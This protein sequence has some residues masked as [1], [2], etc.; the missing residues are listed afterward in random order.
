ALLEHRPLEP[1]D[2]LD[3]NAGRGGDLFRGL[4]GT[5]ACLDLLGAQRALHFDLVLAE[6]GEVATDGSTEPVVHRK[7][8]A[9][10]PPGSS[11]HEIG[12]VLTHRD[13]S[14]L[15]HASPFVSVAILPPDP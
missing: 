2:P 13:E 6:T 3:R 1:P 11:Q 8:E 5:D 14:E 15:L 4:P 12:A 10:A 9:R 7:S